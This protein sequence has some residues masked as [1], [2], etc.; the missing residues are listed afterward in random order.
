MCDTVNTEMAKFRTCLC[1]GSWVTIMYQTSI[2]TLHS[3]ALFLGG[4]LK[5]C[6]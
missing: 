1:Q 4:L 3:L 2:D 6:D 5:C